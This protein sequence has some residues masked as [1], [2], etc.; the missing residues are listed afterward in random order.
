MGMQVQ[1]RVED[2][3][4]LDSVDD[5]SNALHHILPN[6][7]DPAYCYAGCIDW[8]GDTT[9]NCLQIPRF[10]SE[11]DRLLPA[12]RAHG[13][14][15]LHQRIEVLAKRCQAEVHVYLKFRGD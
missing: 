9:F 4:V 10:L 5:P 12:A 13:C 2:G 15:V 1:L 14:E 11:W 3:E 7:D 8:Y 6:Y